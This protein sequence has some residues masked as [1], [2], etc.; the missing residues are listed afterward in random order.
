MLPKTFCLHAIYGVFLTSSLPKTFYLHAFY[1]VFWRPRFQKHCIY[2]RFMVNFDVC[3]SSSARFMVNFDVFAPKNVIFHAFLGVFLFCVVQSIVF[4]HVLWCVLV[5]SLQK[6]CISTRFRVYLHVG[7]PK[8]RT[9]GA[10][11]HAMLLS[12]SYWHSNPS[13]GYAC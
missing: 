12:G 1:G 11:T 7:C 6:H 2:T 4:S 9:T 10:S 5:S 3:A 13:T 8:G